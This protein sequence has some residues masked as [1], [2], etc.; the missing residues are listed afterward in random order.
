MSP[1]DDT[2]ISGSLDKSIRLWDLRSPNCAG[3][4]NVRGRPVASFDPH[5][6][7]FGA[8]IDAELIKLY[9]VRSFDRGNMIDAPI[10]CAS[11]DIILITHPVSPGALQLCVFYEGA[12]CR[13]DTA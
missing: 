11:S 10:G 13:V 12:V 8:G 7:I 5:G 3:L 1:I 4:M 6:L 9:D 2:F